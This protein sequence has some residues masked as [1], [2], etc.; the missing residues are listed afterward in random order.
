MIVEET[1]GGTVGTVTSVANEFVVAKT[2]KLGGSA[3]GCTL[4]RRDPT[5]AR[6]IGLMLD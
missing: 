6:A 2:D 5:I 3:A 4:S 1:A